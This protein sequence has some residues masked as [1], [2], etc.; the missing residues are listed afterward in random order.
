MFGL[1]EFGLAW[2]QKQSV[3]QEIRETARDAVV[4]QFDPACGGADAA[5]V[6]CDAKNRIG[7]NGALVKVTTT[8]PSERRMSSMTSSPRCSKGGSR[9]CNETAGV[10]EPAQ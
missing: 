5:A 8:G 2:F 4:A 1:I 3:S 9:R 6:A 10:A 7:V